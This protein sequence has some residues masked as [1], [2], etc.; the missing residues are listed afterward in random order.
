MKRR[1]LDL[2]VSVGGLLLAG[3][4]LVGGLVLSSNANFA[5]TYV[6]QQLSEQKIAFKT[7]DTLTDE[8][9][10]QACLVTYAG[11]PLTTGK[12]AECYANNFIN[13][14]LQSIAGGKTY[15]EIGDTQT[16]LRTQITAAQAANAS[17][18]TDLQKQ[19]TDLTAA[20]ETVFKGET[21]RGLLLTSY[22]FSEFGAK[23]ALAATVAYLAAGL[24]LLLGLFGLVHAYRTPKTV[25]FAAPEPGTNREPINA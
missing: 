22:G 7:A 18:V 16:Q 25:A 6:T 4:L 20:R 9:K 14:H 13:L 3:L 10:T 19:L 8:E 21:L 24:M 11:Q 23:A 15:A 12:Q 5:N 1:T 2:V 17:N